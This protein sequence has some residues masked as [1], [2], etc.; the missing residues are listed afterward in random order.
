MDTRQGI[1]DKALQL[2]NRQGTGAVSTNHIAA[3]Y[4]IS[5]GNLYYHFHD[6]QEIIRELFRGMYDMWD[7]GLPLPAG[8][9]PQLGDL[10]Q[11]V[12]AGYHNIWTFRFA[13][14]ELVPLLQRDPELRREWLE[15]RRRGFEGFQ[16]LFKAFVDGGVF[17]TSVDRAELAELHEIC[18]LISEFWISNLEVGGHAVNAASMK[19]GV[20]LMLRVLRPYLA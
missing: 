9:A 15:F 3:A 8:R 4:G 5:P 17:R 14:R 16:R 13:Y 18:W 10:Q 1:L 7:L 2:F 11:V 6:K 12:E 20:Q 19:H